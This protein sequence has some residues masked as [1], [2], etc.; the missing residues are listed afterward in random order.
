VSLRFQSMRV[1]GKGVIVQNQDGQSES[2]GRG[3][4][5]RLLKEDAGT[6][7]RSRVPLLVG[8]V[9]ALVVIVGVAV[10]GAA[11]VRFSRSKA[12]FDKAVAAKQITAAL[13]LAEPLKAKYPAAALFV[14]DQG[15]AAA[16]QADMEATRDAARVAGAETDAKEVWNKAQATAD[17]ARTTYLDCNFVNSTELCEEART[18]FLQAEQDAFTALAAKQ[19]A[20]A[21]AAQA[22]VAKTTAGKAGA[23]KTVAAKA[24]T[25][26]PAKA[27]TVVPAKVETAVPAAGKYTIKK[28]DTLWELS[29]KYGLTV[30]E[31][32]KLNNLK[33]DKLQVGQVLVL[34]TAT[35]KATAQP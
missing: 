23:T 7:D 3:V 14:E 8:V 4:R 25:A 11:E 24:G 10:W 21:A 20:A 35:G 22:A 34:G 27:G 28:G 33:S 18:G 16:A 12:E 15:K 19:A 17:L 32:K 29:R 9:A 2:Q 1:T 30:D 5:V 26:A 6:N 31:I 13:T